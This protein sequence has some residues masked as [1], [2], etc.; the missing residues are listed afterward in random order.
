VLDGLGDLELVLEAGVII[1]G[2]RHY[3]SNQDLYIWVDRVH[4]SERI[5]ALHLDHHLL[6]AH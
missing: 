3:F 1:L 6:G 4:L 5:N 2:V